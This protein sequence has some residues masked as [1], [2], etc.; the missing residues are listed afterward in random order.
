MRTFPQRHRIR[1]DRL[2]G[3]TKCAAK[4]I[5]DCSKRE[6]SLARRHAKN[7]RF[8]G[9][10]RP[11]AMRL[12]AAGRRRQGPAS[13]SA[14]VASKALR[15]RESPEP[16]RHRCGGVHLD[17]GAVRGQPHL[18]AITTWNYRSSWTKPTFRKVQRFV[19]DS[20]QTVQV[21][22]SMRR[23]IGADPLRVPPKVDRV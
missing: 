17:Q 19:P 5:R 9:C 8:S 20:R 7:V 13:G 3:A 4:D 1:A 2:R 16:R 22:R 12:R 6:S 18:K 21:E 23:S 15:N 14:A 10:R 11:A